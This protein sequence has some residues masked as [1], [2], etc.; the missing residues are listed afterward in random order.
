MA[1]VTEIA[2]DR[3]RLSAYAPEINLQFNQ[4][5]VR[6]DEPLLG[7]TILNNGNN[8]F[9]IDVTLEVKKGGSGRID[10]LGTLD[11]NAFP[12]TLEGT[13]TQP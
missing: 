9:T 1:T 7:G 11:H 4:L 6:D 8:T 3:Y 12:P 5:F 10:F 2:P 13:L